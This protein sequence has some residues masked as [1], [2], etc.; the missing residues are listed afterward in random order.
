MTSKK[1]WKFH[2]AKAGK[3]KW[4]VSLHAHWKV[5]SLQIRQEKY[6]REFTQLKNSTKI[7]HDLI[8]DLLF[9]FVT[10]MM[11]IVLSIN[12]EDRRQKAKELVLEI[13][14][15]PLL[16]RKNMCLLKMFLCPT[17]LI[18][19]GH[20]GTLQNIDSL[21]SRNETRCC[22]VIVAPDLW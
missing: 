17:S 7:D 10:K 4:I 6:S 9:C 18:Q 12:I 22:L 13:A 14:T 15:W 16:I 3:R 8:I 11:S 19:R 21:T 20:K 1:G 2:A 5:Y